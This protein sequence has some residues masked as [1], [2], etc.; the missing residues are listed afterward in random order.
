MSVHF[1][2]FGVSSRQN[3]GVKRPADVKRDRYLSA[4]QAKEYG[5]VDEVVGHIPTTDAKPP[6]ASTES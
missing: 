1:G 6:G 2:W 3:A 5:L 4:L